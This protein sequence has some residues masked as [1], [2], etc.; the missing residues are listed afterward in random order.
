M[1]LWY[2]WIR[3]VDGAWH[4]LDDISKQ[5]RIPKNAISWAADYLCEHQLAEEGEE[6]A[7]RLH[8]I[9]PRF[10]DVVKG[11]SQMKAHLGLDSPVQ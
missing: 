3:L 2:V 9:H 11:L 7:I 6:N 1:L 10:E 8:G 5:L 4:K